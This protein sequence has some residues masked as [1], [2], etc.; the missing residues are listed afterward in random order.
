[1]EAQANKEQPESK[2][3]EN[4]AFLPSPTFLLCSALHGREPARELAG[5]TPRAEPQSRMRD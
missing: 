1:M 2:Q 5:R 3:E 4:R